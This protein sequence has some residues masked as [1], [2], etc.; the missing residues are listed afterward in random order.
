MAEI[1]GLSGAT[2]KEAG[3]APRTFPAGR[4]CSH[5]DCETPISKYNRG[6]RCWAHSG[7]RIPRLTGR[8]K[9]T[10]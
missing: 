4:I 7:I 1:K 3:R 2:T 9:S 5:P 10:S 6:D 8:K